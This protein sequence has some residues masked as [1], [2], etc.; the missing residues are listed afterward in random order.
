M[1][2][3]LPEQKAVVE[4]QGEKLLLQFPRPVSPSQNITIKIEQIHPNLVLK[5]T[6][7]SSSNSSQKVI[8]GN[9]AKEALP[10]NIQESDKTSIQNRSVDS[11]LGS[12]VSDKNAEPGVRNGQAV[13]DGKV[14]TLSQRQ[15]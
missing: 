3:V 13:L 14:I 11:L 6:D 4:I 7:F 5:L 9:L 8:P 12:P 15:I 2:Q 10:S 1:V